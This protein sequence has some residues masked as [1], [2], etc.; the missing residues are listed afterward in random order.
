MSRESSRREYWSGFS[1]PYSGDLPNPGIEPGSPTLQP[2]S[3]VGSPGEGNGFPGEKTP[4]FFFIFHFKFIYFII[5][6]QLF[7]RIVLVSAKHQHEFTPVFLPGEFHG[8]R[9]GGLHTPHGVTKSQT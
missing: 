9:R 5:E 4:V 6:G 8:W 2:N 7:Y 3:L 1:C